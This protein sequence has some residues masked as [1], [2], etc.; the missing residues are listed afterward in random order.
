MSETL[1][2][3]DAL[4]GDKMIKIRLY[5]QDLTKETQE[6]LLKVFG[7]NCNWDCIPMTEIEIDDEKEI[8]LD[9]FLGDE[10]E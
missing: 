7:D 4:K 5:W 8:I 9:S 2:P 6:R 1:I 3:D 10:F